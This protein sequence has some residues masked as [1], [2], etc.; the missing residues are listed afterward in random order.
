MCV[1]ISEISSYM[2]KMPKHTA[3]P[4]EYALVMSYK[5]SC[6]ELCEIWHAY[7]II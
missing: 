5:R 6:E 4:H 3:C 7:D 2:S 1:P